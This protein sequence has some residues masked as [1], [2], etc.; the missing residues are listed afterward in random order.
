MRDNCEN[1]QYLSV[2]LRNTELGIELFPI[3]WIGSYF[4]NV[5]IPFIDRFPKNTELYSIM[6][7]KPSEMKQEGARAS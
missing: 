2:S 3:F 4:G 5:I 1:Q 6:T 7:T